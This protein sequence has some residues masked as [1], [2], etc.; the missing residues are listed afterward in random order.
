YL[1]SR[2]VAESRQ[3]RTPASHPDNRLIT[4]RYI[5]AQH[6]IVGMIDY[7]PQHPSGVLY[8]VHTDLVGAPR[9]VTDA[10]GQIRWLAEYTPTGRAQ[11]IAGD[12]RLDLR[13]PGQV[14][15]ATTGLHD[16]L[17]RTYDP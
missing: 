11:R 4:R 9:I 17:L 12:L 8:A 5:H 16:N 13:L 3:S 2:L 6:A 10:A 14:A 7:S 1:D 15:D